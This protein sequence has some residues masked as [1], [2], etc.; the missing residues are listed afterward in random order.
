MPSI[1][2]FFPWVPHSKVTPLRDPIAA[3]IAGENQKAR[4]VLERKAVET[5]SVW[6]CQQVSQ[7]LHVSY[8]YLLA[9]LGQFIGKIRYT[10]HGA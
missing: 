9:K 10:I 6:I 3:T 1:D 8:I 7:M 5:R 4:G 2:V